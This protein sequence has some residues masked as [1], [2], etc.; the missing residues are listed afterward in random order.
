MTQGKGSGVTGALE[1]VGCAA[2]VLL[3]LIVFVDVV[4]RNLFG[5]PLPWGTELLEVV[6][7]VMVFVFYPLLALRG[8]HITVDLITVRPSLQMVQRIVAAVVGSVLF[9]VIAGC[10]ARQAQRSFSYGDAS[11]MLQIPTGWVLV[12]MSLL[13]MA[14]VAGFGIA[15]FRTLRLP[16]G[17][18]GAAAPRV[19]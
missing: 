12:G 18:A 1:A 13:S 15:L 11:A 10:V 16:P 14:T 3:M 8:G 2:L 6:L 5:R 9:A 19:E 4:G 17:P 7:A